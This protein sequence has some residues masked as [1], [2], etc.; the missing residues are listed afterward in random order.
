MT[1]QVAVVG[2]G[3]MGTGIAYV[4]AFAG[5]V[6]TVV[7]PD[8]GKAAAM[9][10]ALATATEGAVKR[11]KLTEDAAR[12]MLQRIRRVRAIAEVPAQPDIAIETVSERV[13]LKFEVL[14]QVA[15]LDPGLIGTNTSALSIDRLAAAVPAPERFLGTHFF[16]P[17][18]SFKLI[19]LVRGAAT[20]PAALAQA[21]AFVMGIG[22]EYIVV[23]DVPG[24]ATSRLDFIAALEAIRM[25]ESGV[26][27]VEDIDRAMVLAYHHPVGPLRL[28]DIVGLDVRLDIARVL[29]QTYGP[30]FAP[31]QLLVDKVAR[32]EYGQKSGQGFYHWPEGSR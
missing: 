5:H 13:E 29:E 8:E 1:Q 25:L 6:V 27:S 16:N 12:S 14:R 18:W 4:S 11:G 9:A 17:V 23:K 21:Q 20:S 19:E 7:E 31:P 30:R 10:H 15:A 28:T 24:F 3:T 2:G 32:G 22:R 26:A